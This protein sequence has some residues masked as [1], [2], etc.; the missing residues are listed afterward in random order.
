MKQIFTETYACIKTVPVIK[1]PN[2]RY[3]GP[4]S[5]AKDSTVDRPVYLPTPY[6]IRHIGIDQRK[7]KSTQTIRN[8]S[9]PADTIIYLQMNTP[10]YV[11]IVLLVN[12]PVF[13]YWSITRYLFTGQL[14][15]IYLL[16]KYPVFIYWSSTR[17]LFF[18]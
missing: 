2:Q 12:Y 18:L 15:G 11:I 14:P 16:V 6:S 1:P 10:V 13:I 17:Y 9:A 7:R 8:T 5:L 3:E 4:S